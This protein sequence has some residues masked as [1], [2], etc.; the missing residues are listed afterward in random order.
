MS[1]D[2]AVLDSIAGDFLWFESFSSHIFED[3]S[4][5]SHN[6]RII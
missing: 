1:L 3:A 2:A 5:N 6:D 4:I